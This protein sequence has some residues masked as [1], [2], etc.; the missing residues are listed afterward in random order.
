M[1]LQETTLPEGSQL[2]PPVSEPSEKVFVRSREA[3]LV[4]AEPDLS[5]LI[6]DENGRVITLSGNLPRNDLFYIAEGL[7]T[8]SPP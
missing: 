8:L 1:E 7:K 2:L 4:E 5:T 6:W 3:F